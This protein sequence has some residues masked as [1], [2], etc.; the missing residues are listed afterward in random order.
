MHRSAT[1]QV[2]AF[3]IAAERGHR[4]VVAAIGLK[5]PSD[6]TAND[7]CFSCSEVAELTIGLAT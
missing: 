2:E 7:H 4:A 3:P 6:A 1:A 5:E